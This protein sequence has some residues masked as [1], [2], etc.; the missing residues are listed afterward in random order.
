MSNFHLFDQGLVE[1]FNIILSTLY[2]EMSAAKPISSLCRRDFSTNRFHNLINSIRS[3]VL[4]SAFSLSKLSKRKQDSRLEDGWS[5]PS[6]LSFYRPVVFSKRGLCVNFFV[7]LFIEKKGARSAQN[8]INGFVC[9]D[10]R[11][12]ILKRY[13]DILRILTERY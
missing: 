1:D 12:M 13:R 2:R 6:H 7:E 8:K 4:V 10:I 11:T 9:S 5:F 3:F